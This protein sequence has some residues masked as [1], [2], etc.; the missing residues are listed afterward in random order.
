LNATRRPSLGLG[1]FDG[2]GGLKRFGF[3]REGWSGMMGAVTH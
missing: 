3:A 2:G 1:D